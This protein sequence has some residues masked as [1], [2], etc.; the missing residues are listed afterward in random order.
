MHFWPQTTLL[1]KILNGG[2]LNVDKLSNNFSLWDNHVAIL[3][4]TFD[5]F[6]WDQNDENHSV[7]VDDLMSKDQPKLIHLPKFNLMPILPEY[8]FQSDDDYK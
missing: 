5:I 8:K 3:E 6:K 1:E 7:Q 4:N 2:C